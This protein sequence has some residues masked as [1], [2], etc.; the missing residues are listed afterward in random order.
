M[1]I[2]LHNLLIEFFYIQN[3]QVG[4][5]RKILYQHFVASC[6]TGDSFSSENIFYVIS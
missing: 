1:N 2:L 6:P 4:L 3:R 5:S